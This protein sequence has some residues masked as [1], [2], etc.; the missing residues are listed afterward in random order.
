M[1]DPRFLYSVVLAG[2]AYRL[3]YIDFKT[4]EIKRL[5]ETFVDSDKARQAFE[6]MIDG[7]V[8]CYLQPQRF[9]MNVR[10]LAQYK[11]HEKRREVKAQQ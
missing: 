8:S 1:E 9:S 5:E 6:A 2:K 4:Q 11:R 7:A 3:R 10:S